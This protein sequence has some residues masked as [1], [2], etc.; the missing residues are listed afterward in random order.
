VI[1][2]VMTAQI[3]AT[4]NLEKLWSVPEVSE[5]ASEE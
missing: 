4:Y 3:R 2:H 1:V 5:Q